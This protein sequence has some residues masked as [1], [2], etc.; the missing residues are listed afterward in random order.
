MQHMPN[1]VRPFCHLILALG[2]I[3]FFLLGCCVAYHTIHVLETW[4]CG[5]DGGRLEKRRCVCAHLCVVA[6]WTRQQ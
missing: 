1:A 6:E 3:L 4:L 2:F 5:R